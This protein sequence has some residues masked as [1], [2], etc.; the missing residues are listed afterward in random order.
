MSAPSHVR[1]ISIV[2]ALSVAT[3]G[4]FLLEYSQRTPQHPPPKE[5]PVEEEQATVL[6]PEPAR[7][8]QAKVI[9]P[10]PQSAPKNLVRTFKCEQGGRVS[11]SDQP[12][13]NGANVLAVTA[14]EDPSPVSPTS[15][16]QKMKA[17]AAAMEA[18]RLAREKQFEIAV[19]E[20]TKTS[21]P[22]ADLKKRECKNIDQAIAS[23]DSML[24]QA[25]TAQEGDYWAAQRRELTDRRFSLGC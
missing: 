6:S 17:Q 7:L 10:I 13:A 23:I 3:G 5:E 1:F 16:L 9:N 22:V 21:S 14:A 18:D 2:L 20:Q 11:Y 24:R 4:W 25:H 8:T 19:A 12:C 15:N